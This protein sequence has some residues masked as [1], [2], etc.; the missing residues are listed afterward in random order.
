MPGGDVARSELA[1]RGVAGVA[2]PGLQVAGA[3]LG[4][5]DVQPDAEPLAQRGA[6]RRV[7]VRRRAQAVVAV[8]RADLRDAGDPH[9]EVEQADRVAPAGEQDEHRAARGEQA[10]GADAVEQVAHRVLA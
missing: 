7:G 5:A 9:R 4:P 6:E 8:E 2:R 10:S 3:A 1:R